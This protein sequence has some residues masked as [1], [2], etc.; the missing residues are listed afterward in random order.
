MGKRLASWFIFLIVPTLG[1]MLGCNML[2]AQGMRTGSLERF[3]ANPSL[4]SWEAFEADVRA[5]RYGPD[6]SL[7]PQVLTYHDAQLHR[8]FPN[9]MALKGITPNQYVELEIKQIDT[10]L[11][12]LRKSSSEDLW[13]VISAMALQDFNEELV[14]TACEIAARV[15]RDRF[16]TIAAD[17]VRLH[18]EEAWIIKRTRERWLDPGAPG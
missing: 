3:V 4:S 10:A 1:I 15:S 8:D 11:K 9:S 13:R 16:E 5:G 14:W 6:A 17:V 18:P 7:F 2:I 12:R